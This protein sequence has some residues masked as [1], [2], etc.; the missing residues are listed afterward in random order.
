MKNV[1]IAAE[2]NIGIAS[3]YRIFEGAKTE[4]D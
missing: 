2:L 1:D 3:F 4:L